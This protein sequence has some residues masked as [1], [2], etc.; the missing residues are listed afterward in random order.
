VNQSV[1][2]EI[3]II[4]RRIHSMMSGLSPSAAANGAS[5]MWKSGV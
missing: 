3:G 2:A 5:I 1:A 4:A